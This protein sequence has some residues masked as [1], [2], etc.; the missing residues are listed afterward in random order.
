M[1]INSLRILPRFRVQ[2]L[3]NHQ[4]RVEL[5]PDEPLKKCAQENC[6]GIFE[7]PERRTITAHGET[8]GCY[9]PRLRR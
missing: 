9:L 4:I 5:K 7:V 2:S 3:Q 1:E 8:V 6:R